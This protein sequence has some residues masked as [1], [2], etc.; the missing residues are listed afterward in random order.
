MRP[1]THA[2]AAPA[3]SA[4]ARRLRGRIV[5]A[6]A[7]D[8]AARE[9]MWALFA[10]YYDQVSRA[11]FDADLA[12]KQ[13]VILL[14]DAGALR[15]FSTLTVTRGEALGRRFVAVFSGDTVLDAAYWGQTALQRAFLR[16][17]MRTWARHP[18]TPVYWFLIT[19]GWRTYL[20]LSR[21]FPEHWPRHDRPTAP[22]P[23]A[24][25][26]RLAGAMFPGAWRPE[27]GVLEFAACPGRLREDVAPITPDLLRHADIRFFAERN[28]G[29][30]RGDELCCLG[31]VHLPLAVSYLSKLAWRTALRGLRRGG[32]RIHSAHSGRGDP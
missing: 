3:T 19:K 10:R 17:V 29:H 12:K 26:D 7:L 11:T 28:P 20:L 1:A 24:V 13:H 8:A 31:R 5:A 21:N 22:W 2:A 9:T 16:Y 14:E 25:L 15:G 32:G 30:A 27:R 6:G 23:A 18:L 4:L